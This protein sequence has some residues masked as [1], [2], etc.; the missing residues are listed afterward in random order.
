MPHYFLPDEPGI[1]RRYRFVDFFFHHPVD[2]HRIAR[3]GDGAISAAG[4]L[5]VVGPLVG[6]AVMRFS[7]VERVHQR[8]RLVRRSGD[9]EV[10]LEQPVPEHAQFIEHRPAQHDIVRAAE[11][12][13]RS[14]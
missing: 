3:G 8:M 9:G 5:N 12:P 6:L 2:S 11:R 10:R 14:R 13:R 4:H 1:D 7:P